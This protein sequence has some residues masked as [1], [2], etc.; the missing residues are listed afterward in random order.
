MIKR[1]LLTVVAAAGLALAA[2]APALAAQPYPINFKN[3]P[4]GSYAS[5]S[6]VT[7]S[8]GTVTLASTGLGSFTYTDPFA[9]YSNDGAN[10][11]GPYQ[12]GMDVTG[13]QHLVRLQR[14]RR[15]LERDHAQ[16]HVDPG[17]D[18]AED[19]RR[20]LGQVVHPRPLVLERQRLPP[21]VGRRSGRRGR[22]RLDRHLVRQG[23]RRGRLP[24]E[25]DALPPR[26]VERD[27]DAHAAERGRDEPDQPEEQVPERDHDD[28][29]EGSRS[30]AV[31][32][33]DPPR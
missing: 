15:L 19:A 24:A 28:G 12:S 4:L 16:R 27:A 17:R 32:A 9:N 29:A 7:E 13:L 5:I 26:R 10:G 33:G 1:T 18:A 25:G 3:F 30:P 23:P 8:G 20:P 22:L 6:G 14:A 31:F 11:S 21:H 2:S